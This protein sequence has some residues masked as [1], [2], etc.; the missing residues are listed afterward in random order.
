MRK[1]KRS[2]IG[3][4]I[5][6][7]KS[8]IIWVSRGQD[9]IVSAKEVGEPCCNYVLEEYASNCLLEVLLASWRR[10]TILSRGARTHGVSDRF[11][12]SLKQASIKST[13]SF[14]L[15]RHASILITE[16]LGNLLRMSFIYSRMVARVS[17]CA[18]II[19][20]TTLSSYRLL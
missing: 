18:C 14:P 19:G 4:L 8:Q 10:T 20:L 7:L 15:L 2:A 13:S 16:E 12:G 3:D 9:P 11:L 5:I 1:G 17:L 6:L